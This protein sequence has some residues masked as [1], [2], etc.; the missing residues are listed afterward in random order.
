MVEGIPQSVLSDSLER[1]IGGRRVRAAVF[2]TYE[3]DPAFFELHV[4][5]LMFA[6]AFSERHGVKRAQLEEELRSVERVAVYYDRHGLDDSHGAAQL[7]YKR[8]EVSLPHGVLHAKHVLLLVSGEDEHNESLLLVTTSANL[9][10]PGWWTNVEVAHVHEIPAGAEDALRDDLLEAG[11]QPGLL[12]RIARLDK[13]GEEHEALR[14]I[15]RHLDERVQSPDDG[16]LADWVR[17]RLWV[18]RE[19]F[20]EFLGE[21]MGVT[22]GEYDL[23]V[24]SP[25]FEDT[26]EAKTLRALIDAVRPRSTRVL[27]PRDDSARALC[28]QEFY[29]AVAALP[30]VAW[31]RL[32]SQVTRWSS[33]DP[34]ASERYVHAKGYR[35]FSRKER[36]ELL[37]VGSVNLT[38]AAHAGKAGNLES[39]IFLDLSGQGRPEGWLAKLGDATPLEFVT[40]QSEDEP[41]LGAIL[42]VSFRFDW[43]TGVLA[44]FW[45]RQPSPPKAASV[46]AGKEHR[47]R[48][49][50]IRFDEWV[51]LPDD[52]GARMRD[53]LRSTSF[54]DVSVGTGPPHR[55]LVREE[56]MAHRPSVLEDLS[57][58]EILEYWSL[59][60]PEQRDAFL[61]AKVAVLLAARGDMDEEAMADDDQRGAQ[62]D[63]SMFDRFAGIFHAFS[64]LEE[65][66][67]TWLD[68]DAGHGEKE[69]VYRLFGAKHDSLPSLIDKVLAD[70]EGDRV[71]RY[72]TL[73]CCRQLLDDVR[74]RHPHFTDSHADEMQSVYMAL[75][76]CDEIRQGFTFGTVAERDAFFEWFDK[77]FFM[78]MKLPL[79]EGKAP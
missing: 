51:E 46:Q 40:Q 74:Q 35:L 32:P 25:F 2:V 63:E 5:P 45:E 42:P 21:S 49:A 7:D 59:L 1:A 60:T 69:A 24:L 55:V 73:M 53:L 75:E 76:R 4:L 6:K 13:T 58:E 52:V 15:T 64:C 26:A 44:Y 22:Q 17:P 50:P 57:S 41:D 38:R 71:N 14:E 43:C 29:E 48:I 23:E 31:G 62:Q 11:G 66:L 12:D 8:I 67:L 70:E 27:L 56:N 36:W 28:S 30:D 18:G 34:D 77:S 78:K 10:E 65:R 33:K 79:A 19:T 61:S 20:A 72:V 37:V 47:F 68:E 54:L 16:L 9:T 39:A 3:F